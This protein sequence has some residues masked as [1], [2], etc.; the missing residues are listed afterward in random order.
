GSMRRLFRGDRA[1]RLLD[2]RSGTL[3]RPAERL[4]RRPPP[5]CG[6]AGERRARRLSAPFRGHRGGT[7]VRHDGCFVTAARLSSLSLQSVEKPLRQA[8][9]DLILLAAVLAAMV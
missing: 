1:G 4:L 5:A 9:P 8:C 7:H 2:S 6:N 3:F